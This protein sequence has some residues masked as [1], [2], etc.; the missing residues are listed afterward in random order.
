M[1]KQKRPLKF[2]L[3]FAAM[4]ALPS[5]AMAQE[6]PPAGAPVAA[7][8]PETPPPPA[9]P[10]DLAPADG[11]AAPAPTLADVSAKVDGLE[12]SYGGTKAIVDGLSKIKVSGY[13][14]GR[15]ELHQY[16]QVGLDPGGKPSIF[17]RFYVRRGRLK[18]VYSGNN[19]E[20]LLQIDATGSGVVLKDAEASFVD[21]WTPFNFKLTAGQFKVPFGYEVLQ[22]SG[23]REMPERS[24]FIREF[25]PNER[26]RGVRLNASRD[27]FRFSGAV[28]NGNFI[29]DSIYA[30]TDPNGAKDII[31]RVG[32]D[33]DSVVFGVSGSY[34]KEVKTTLAKPA[35]LTGVD[36]N[37]DKMLTGAEIISTIPSPASYLYYDRLRLGADIQAYIDVPSVGGLALKGE[38]ALQRDKN[39]STPI[40]AANA[41]NDVTAYGWYVAGIQNV[42]DYLGVV[43]RVDQFRYNVAERTGCPNLV[44]NP[45]SDKTTTFGGGFLLYGSTNIKFSVIGE[46]VTG[47]RLTMA[48]FNPGMTLPVTGTYDDRITFQLQAKF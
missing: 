10:A 12:E 34:G 11:A 16:S 13:V 27:W 32:G 48:G 15:L 23:D 44:T 33:F 30:D 37:G 6:A 19:A 3:V 7:P 24:R 18:V 26:D 46:K 42:G 43:V 17:D 31:G 36:A 9:P 47:K 29:Q 5:L 28:V 1:T 21:T 40:V 45:T 14:Q 25:F 41:C 39:V 22:S 38:F 4:C 8:A 2:A 20:Y 35:V